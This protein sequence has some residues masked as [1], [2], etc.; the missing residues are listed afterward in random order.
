MI[1]QNT[2]ASGS[3]YKCRGYMLKVTNKHVKAAAF[4][5]NCYF[6]KA[7]VIRVLMIL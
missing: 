7:Q 2:E 3:K 4:R 1:R 6:H 5:F